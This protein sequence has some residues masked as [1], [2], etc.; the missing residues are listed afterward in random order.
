MVCE[1]RSGKILFQSNHR[2]HSGQK[3]SEILRD[4]SCTSCAECQKHLIA[5]HLYSGFYFDHRFSLPSESDLYIEILIATSNFMIWHPKSVSILQLQINWLCLLLLIN[6]SIHS[7][8]NIGV[9]LISAIL[10]FTWNLLS[11]FQCRIATMC[12]FRMLGSVAL[13]LGL[14]VL[15][16]YYSLALVW[17]S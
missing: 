8:T 3:Q 5:D 4:N 16:H 1:T 17:I 12:G 2:T 13:R 10:C 6:K 7:V 9:R 15:T 14:I 11:Y